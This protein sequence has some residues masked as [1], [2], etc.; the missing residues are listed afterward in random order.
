MP[1]TL[2]V[3]LALAT[4]SLAFSFGVDDQN[5]ATLGSL[6]KSTI[7]DVISTVS[8]STDMMPTISTTIKTREPI[9]SKEVPETSTVGIATTK[10]PTKVGRVTKVTSD[11]TKNQ[12]PSTSKR[13]NDSLNVVWECP[14]ITGIGIE[15]SCDFPHTLRCTGDRTALQVLFVLN[16][17]FSKLITI[18]KQIVIQKYAEVPSDFA[19]EKYSQFY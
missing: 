9:E 8:E 10:I 11:N 6:S 5:S 7:E 14:N 2:Q 15:C 4:L 19:F 17:H 13:R 16:R 1:R 18:K 3:L 12:F